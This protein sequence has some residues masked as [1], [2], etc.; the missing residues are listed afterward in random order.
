MKK[1]IFTVLLLT[2]VSGMAANWVYFSSTSDGKKF[3]YDSTNISGKTVGNK[4]H[5]TWV[6]II[7]PKLWTVNGNIDF[8]EKAEQWVF[9]CN[10]KSRTD[11]EIFYYN[12]R[13]NWQPNIDL[14]K[15]NINI[16]ENIAV[17][18]DDLFSD[19][20]LKGK[21]QKILSLE[22]FDGKEN[23]EKLEGENGFTGGNLEKND[24][25]RESAGIS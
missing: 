18:K 5:W 4:G 10:G 15:K 24:K 3:Y 19:D 21:N 14:I 13:E 16:N 20:I 22:T 1:I 7:F 17:E 2:S 11:D 25:N 12:D 8:N 23:S 9:D 6:K